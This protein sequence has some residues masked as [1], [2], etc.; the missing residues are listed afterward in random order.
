MKF[1]LDLPRETLSVPVIRRI[2]G[3]TLRGLG[4]SEACVADILVAISE[5]CT[6]V[7]QH[8]DATSRYEVIAGIDGGECV[9]KIVDRGQG[10]TGETEKSVP[11]DS[12]SGRGITIMKA[13]VDDVSFDSRPDSGT[14]VYLQKR[15]SWQDETAARHHHPEL[16]KTAG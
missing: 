11:P 15:L 5:A 14:V 4:V 12:E 8:A 3:D 2:L 7:V 10:F 6:N 16:L 13:L 1:S 9:L